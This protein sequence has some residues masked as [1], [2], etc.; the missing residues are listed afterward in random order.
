MYFTCFS[1]LNLNTNLRVATVDDIRYYCNRTWCMES[2]F[3]IAEALALTC[4]RAVR[5]GRN[6]RRGG[7]TGL[8]RRFR[9][10]GRCVARCRSTGPCSRPGT[11]TGTCRTRSCTCPAD[12]SRSVPGCCT[13][14]DLQTTKHSNGI[15]NKHSC[16]GNGR[17]TAVYDLTLARHENR[18]KN[19]L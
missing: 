8:G 6:T 3:R 19:K 17:C 15:R 10:Y 4:T 18:S 1:L 9:T 11:R 13:R 7:C 5:L 12:G 14:P 2:F 16:T